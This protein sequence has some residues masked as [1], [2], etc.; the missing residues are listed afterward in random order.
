MKIPEFKIELGIVENLTKSNFNS[1]AQ[2][3]CGVIDPETDF[4]F[5]HNSTTG[6]ESQLRLTY[7][8]FKMAKLFNFPTLSSE[9][10]SED[11]FVAVKC[12]TRL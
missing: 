8:S 10:V 4:D 6:T 1:D 7:R 12:G 5:Q 11:S 2:C 9:H 3:G